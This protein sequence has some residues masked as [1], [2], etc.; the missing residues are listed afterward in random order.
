MTRT[1]IMAVPWNAQRLRNA[2]RIAQAVGAE[3][4]WDERRDA[5]YTW[6]RTLDAAGADPVII[7]EDDVQL[8]DGWRDKI[9]AAIA[10]RPDMVIQFFS[11]RPSDTESHEEPGRTF[12]MNQCYYL[13][14]NTANRLLAYSRYWDRDINGYDMCM[15]DWMKANKLKYWMHIPSLVQHQ[16]WA[17][18]IHPRRPR[19]RQAPSFTEESPDG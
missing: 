6:R 1:L 2:V 11:L 5:M 14:A 7:L 19:N 12:M 8:V 9:E 4:I 18:E 10:E 13:P 3:I 15:A 17:S 16:T